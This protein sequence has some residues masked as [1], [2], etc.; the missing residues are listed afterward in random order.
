MFHARSTEH[1]ALELG[2]LRLGSGS[3]E[4]ELQMEIPVQAV[5]QEHA[6]RGRRSRRG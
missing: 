1:L 6:L 2:L 3:T 5:S 4:V